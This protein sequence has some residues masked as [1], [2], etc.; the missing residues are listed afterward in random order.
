MEFGHSM[1]IARKLISD[2]I[3]DFKQ[4]DEG[5]KLDTKL[6]PKKSCNC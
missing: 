4:N 6:E 1:M 5:I 2:I 3:R